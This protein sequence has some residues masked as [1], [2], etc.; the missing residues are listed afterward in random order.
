MSIVI[1]GVGNEDFTK[2]RQLDDADVVDSHGNKPSR[3]IVRFVE[4]RK[5]KNNRAGLSKETLEEIPGQVTSFYAGI[6]RRPNPPQNVNM[7]IGD[8]LSNFS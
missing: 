2:M 6:N 3:D 5:Y 8:N 1:V 7:S 4:H